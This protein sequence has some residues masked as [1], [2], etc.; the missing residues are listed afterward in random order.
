MPITTE[1]K[2][3]MYAPFQCMAQYFLSKGYCGIVYS[4]TV[5]PSGKNVVLFDK[6]A[7]YPCGMIRRFVIPTGL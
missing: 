4:S 1:N 3:I 7:A 5:F 6:M 2:S